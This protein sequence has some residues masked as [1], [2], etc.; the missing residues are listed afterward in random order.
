V[1]QRDTDCFGRS[2]PEATLPDA[3]SMNQGMIAQ[4]MA[5]WY[6]RQALAVK[7]LARLEPAANRGR[8]GLWSQPNVVP[9]W[10]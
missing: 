9:P 10:N 5:W 1:T 4:W 8:I 6:P 2:V 3:R 7:E